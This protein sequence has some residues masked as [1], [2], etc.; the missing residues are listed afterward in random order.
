M[1]E[2]TMDLYMK[3]IA[4]EVVYTE[5]DIRFYWNPNN[6][7]RYHRVSKQIMNIFKSRKELCLCNTDSVKME[8]H[9]SMI[10]SLYFTIDKTNK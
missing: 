4:K 7:Q 10:L 2:R 1:D 6:V 5:Q 3:D 9:I 8:H